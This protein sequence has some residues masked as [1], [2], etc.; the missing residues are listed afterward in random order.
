MK[1]FNV[2]G[3]CFPEQHY[4]VDI[5]HTLDSMQ[6]LVEGETYFTVNRGRQYG[7]TTTLSLLRNRLESL[8]YVVFFISFEG[9]EDE[10][11][12][13]VY[14]FY[15]EFFSLMEEKIQNAREAGIIGEESHG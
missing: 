9:L 4:M 14:T 7:K 2:T 10:V 11:F 3:T 8:G 12:E 1:K 13:S 6:K 15:P 5:S